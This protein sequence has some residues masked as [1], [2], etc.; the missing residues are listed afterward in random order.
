MMLRSAFTSLVAAALLAG[1]V[2]PR[3][4]L[5]QANEPGSQATPPSGE[6]SEAPPPPP[7]APPPAPAPAPAEP[8]Q[9]AP[10]SQPGQWVYTQQYGWIWMDYGDSFTY[11]PP[12]GAGEPLAYV[13]YP[14]VGWTWI[15]APWVWGIGPWPY[16]GVRGPAYFA[17]YRHGWWR[18]PTHWHYRPAPVYARTPMTVHGVRGPVTVHG[19][20]PAP[21]FNGA[22]PSPRAVASQHANSSSHHR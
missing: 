4:V 10:P 16:F 1:S 11:V 8:Q 14:V 19:V 17:W 7:P 20:R 12:S 6:P 22:R 5:A 13:Y 15:V 18:T 21:A 9:A 2:A 3:Q